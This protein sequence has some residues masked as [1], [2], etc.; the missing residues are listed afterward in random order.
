M[1]LFAKIS[2]CSMLVLCIAVLF[3]G[4]LLITF[5][6]ENALDRET[7][8]ALAKYQYDKFSVQ[9]ELIANQDRLQ[10]GVE[11][12]DRMLSMLSADLNGEVAFFSA[13]KELLF[14]SVPDEF[15]VALSS[16]MS[17]K[18]IV[19]EFKQSASKVYLT[20]SGKITQGKLSLYLVSVTDIT[21][22]ANQ[23]EA[24]TES[25]KSAYF[26][27]IGI[28]M[29]FVLILSVLLTRPINRLTKAATKMAGGH[30]HERLVIHSSDEIGELSGSFNLMASAVEDKISALSETARQKED[31]VASFAH[32][33]KTPLTSVIGYADML[34]QKNLPP[35]ETKSAAWYILNEGLRLEALSLK[36]MDL[37]V[38]N[39]QDFVLEEMSATE[40]LQNILDGLQPLLNEHRVAPHLTADIGYVKVEYDLFKTLL[41]N[42]I[43]NS[44]KA[45]CTDIWILGQQTDEHYRITVTDNGRGIP[46]S[47][48]SRISE[49]FYM[50]DKSRSRKQHGV[51]LGLSLASKIAEI[52]GGSLKFNSEQSKRITTVEFELIC[53]GGVAHD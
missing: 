9:A 17:E 34:Y 13:D 39:R 45:E 40:L 27:T 37:I 35:D 48:L 10:E 51:G 1:R 32:E 20:V 47:E 18:M 49:A 14:S 29:A 44:V 7:E 12:N 19:H 23:K 2:I 53:E 16:G 52:H 50:V 21:S 30:Y 33:L 46:P 42:L 3:S 43:D 25:F 15:S 28:S 5:S 8:R 38:L 41:L 11:A 24:M 26:I 6:Y 4:Y 31:F 36:L 22:V